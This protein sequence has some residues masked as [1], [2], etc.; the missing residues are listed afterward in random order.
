M[1]SGPPIGF[2]FRPSRWLLAA[3]LLVALLALL[4]L[5]MSGLALMPRLLGGGLLLAFAVR[6]LRYWRQPR[7]RAVVWRDGDDASL[8][9]SSGFDAAATLMHARA[10]GPLIVLEFAW[11]PR[12]RACLWLLPDNLD[13][14]HRRHLRMRILA[15]AGAEESAV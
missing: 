13:A 15:R 14:V 10:L 12:Q 11:E 1:T 6:R 7:V 8:A 9:L 4:A 3:T 5:A 2:E